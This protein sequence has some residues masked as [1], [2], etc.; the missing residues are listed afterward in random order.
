MNLGSIEMGWG[1]GWGER[2]EERLKG[3]EMVRQI[4]G[5]RLSLSRG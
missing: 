4:F 1:L 3:G 2:K 5:T